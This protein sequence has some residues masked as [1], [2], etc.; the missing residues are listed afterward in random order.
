V[1]PVP[2]F[3]I[4]LDLAPEDRFI[5][6]IEHFNDTLSD[7]YAKLTST[8]FVSDIFEK[9][10]KH[11]GPETDEL[12]GEIRGISKAS[13]IPVDVIQ[14]V[15]LLYELQT[16]MVPFVNFSWPW[17]NAT[18]SSEASLKQG[19][20]S[21]FGCTGIIARSE[22]DDT[23]YHAR[24]LDFSFAYWLQ[25]MTYNGVFTKGGKE[26]FTAQMIAAY[27]SMVTGIRKGSNGYAIEINTRY[28]DHSGGN[29]EIFTN[30]FDKKRKPSGWIKRK[31]LESV[32]NYEDAVSAFS[33]TPYISTEFN[34]ISGVKKGIILAREPDEVAYT[35]DLAQNRFIIMTNFDYVYHDHKEWLDPTCL[36]GIGHSRRIGA[37]RILNKS[38]VI[39]PELLYSVL[40]DEAVMA[41]DTIFQAIMNVEK[42]IYNTSL[43]FCKSCG[44]CVDHGQCRKSTETCCT[45]GEHYTFG[46]SHLGGYRCGC[47]ADGA[48]RF[49]RTNMTEGDEDC[50]S[51]ESHFTLD[52]P[53]TRRCGKKKSSVMNLI[54]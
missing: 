17:D 37:E 23:V 11:R 2:E 18:T 54:V 13:G 3:E 51:F 44:G 22:A 46:C 50:C 6:V 19:A 7:V 48:C 8:Y 49:P 33:T 16:I 52:C 5:K 53:S 34:I 45:I 31:V 32:D 27:S 1:L 21:I 4:N 41:P 10:A 30:M 15:Q 43:P 35:I 20:D 39:T 14:S 28:L 36:K 29:K 12:M 26:L 47:L 9:I 40:N 25:N 42:S 38:A 24:N